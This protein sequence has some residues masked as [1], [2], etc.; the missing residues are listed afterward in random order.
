M[1][2]LLLLLLL[3]MRMRRPLVR[4]PNALA[5]LPLGTLQVAVP[6]L[7]CGLLLTQGVRFFPAV[8]VS[9]LLPALSSVML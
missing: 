9:A 6:V 4:M 8:P 5:A 2:L 3:R 7:W 1:L